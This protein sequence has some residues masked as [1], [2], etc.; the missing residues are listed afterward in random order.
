MTLFVIVFMMP[1]FVWHLWDI[2]KVGAD[3]I[4]FSCHSD[5]FPPWMQFRWWEVPHLFIKLNHW[6]RLQEPRLFS[7]ILRSVTMQEWNVLFRMDA[8]SARKLWS[9]NLLW[10][11]VVGLYEGA[12]FLHSADE[13]WINYASLTNFLVLL[14]SRS[15]DCTRSLF[16]VWAWSELIML[17]RLQLFFWVSWKQ[18]SVHTVR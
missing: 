5:F 11:Q 7:R 16:K 8:T 12:A 1:S 13:A 6:V 2:F 10:A 18:I 17:H 3:D 15:A 4:L 9:L 14:C